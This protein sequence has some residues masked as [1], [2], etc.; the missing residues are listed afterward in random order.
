MRAIHSSYLI[1]LDLL[2]LIIYHYV[3]FSILFPISPS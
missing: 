3:V 1:L 2:T